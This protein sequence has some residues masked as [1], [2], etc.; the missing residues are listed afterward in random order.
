MSGVFV[1]SAE[2]L[3]VEPD[4]RPRVRVLGGACETTVATWA[5]PFRYEPRPGDLLLVYGKQGRYWVTGVERGRGRSQLVFGGDAELRAAGG[6]LQF[7][8]DAG[9][10]LDAPE[11]LVEADQ[12][13]LDAGQNVQRIGEADTTVRGVLDERAGA[14]ERV[15]DGDENVTAGRSET[16]AARAVRIDGDV[17]R[18]G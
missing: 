15:V 2:V 7:G 11:V 17:L 8:A 5:L 13:E 18:L 3:A 1:G 12:L 16:V 6:S 10:R 4:G 14:S 9:V